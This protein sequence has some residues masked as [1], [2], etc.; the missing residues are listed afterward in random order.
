MNRASL[1]AGALAA[2]GALVCGCGSAT[3]VQVA[4]SHPSPPP[5]PKAQVARTHVH[6]HVESSITRAQA[7][8]FDR[9]VN[10]TVADVPGASAYPREK[11]SPAETRNNRELDRCVGARRIR[12]IA[13]VKSPQLQ[14]G[15]GVTRETFSSS[16]TIS[17]NAHLAFREYT[18]ARSPAVRACLTRVLRKSLH[19]NLGKARYGS[20]AV[21]LL[22]NGIHGAEEGAGL[23]FTTTIVSGRTGRQIPIY[24]DQIGF[25]LGA[26]EINL[27]DSSIVQ[28]VATTT[29]EQLLSLLLERATAYMP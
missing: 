17:A 22:P 7:L 19:R 3:S 14:R 13:E 24:T 10:L 1:T 9:A 5:A 28:P 27:H 2:T 6:P 29:E 26:A 21:R 15:K 12:E 4:G 25:I 18:A 23:R 20:V 8:A 16:V 11:K